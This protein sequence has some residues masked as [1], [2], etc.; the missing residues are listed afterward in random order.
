MSQWVGDLG[1]VDLT[2]LAVMAFSV[3]LGLWRGI[4]FELVSLL[5][6]LVAYVLA[7]A[8]G[9]YVAQLW[10]DG[11][12]HPAGA[13]AA[14][15][16]LWGSYALVF[17]V[18]LL[19]CTGL[20]RLLRALLMRTPL[21]VVDHLLG[22][23]FGLLRAALIMVIIATLVALSPF[24]KSKA[25]HDSHGQVWLSQALELLQPVLPERLNLQ[26]SS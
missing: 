26:F 18:V 21:S 17:V 13:S 19:L 10:P 23:V 14:A 5:G 9:P 4:A 7:C 2:L 3:I 24:A 16:R 11:G 15:F 1:W 20:A 25:W 22:G 12:S 8:A 6:W